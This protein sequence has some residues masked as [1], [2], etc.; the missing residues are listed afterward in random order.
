MVAPLQSSPS[1][2]ADRRRDYGPGWHGAALYYWDPVIAP[3]G[4]AFYDGSMF[5]E[6]RGSILVGGCPVYCLYALMSVDGARVRRW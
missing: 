6:W 1:M 5:P 3:N 2:S 4:M